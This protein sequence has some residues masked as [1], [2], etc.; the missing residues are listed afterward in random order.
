MHPNSVRLHLGRLL[1]AGL[2]EAGAGQGARGRPRKLWR[3]AADAR[4][5]GEPPQAY[6]EL[7]DWLSRSVEGIGADRGD[8]RA[9]G[10]RIGR[11]IAAD[12][13]GVACADVLESALAAMGFQ[14]R[15]S[16][17]GARTAFTLCNCPY[18]EVATANPGVV[19]ALHLGVAEGLVQATDPATR[20]TEFDAKDPTE[21]GCLIEIEGPAPATAAEATR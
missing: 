13:S 16:D 14:P 4:I 21:A 7:A 18:R 1:D 15:R 12:S 20:L 2:V 6:R 3:V 19:C 10:R 5:G 8:I 11:E 17:Q 9:Q